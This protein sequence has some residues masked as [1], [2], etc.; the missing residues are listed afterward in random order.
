VTARIA[1]ALLAVVA[2][3]AAVAACG[4]TERVPDPSGSTLRTTW[5]DTDGDGALEP[6]PGEALLRRTELAPAGQPGREIARLG[7]VTDVHLADEESPAHLPFL[8]RLGPPFSSTFRPQEALQPRVLTGIVRSLNDARPQAVLEGGD[9]AD[10]AQSN[11]LRQAQSVLDGGLVRPDTGGR[12]YEGPQL[13]SNPDPLFYRP[14]VDAPRYEGLLD[15]AARPFRSPGLRAPWHPVLGNHDILVAGELAPT[16]KTNALATGDRALTR[17]DREFRLPR[18]EEALAPGAVDRVLAAGLPGVTERRTP[19]P[20]R[21]ELSA[22][23][24]VA[25]L[26]PRSAGARLDYSFDVGRELRVIALDIVARDR[27]SGGRVTEATLAFLRSELARAG[28][29]RIAVAT[30]QPLRSSDGGA[31]V[32]ALLDHDRRVVATLAGHTHRNRIRPR[33]TAAGGYWQIETASL[34]D[35]PQQARMLALVRTAGGGLALSTWLVD[36]APG[37]PWVDAA[38]RLAYLD[39]QGGRPTGAASRPRDRNALLF[40]PR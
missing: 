8:D 10:S 15:A 5:R 4:S 29:R 30:H 1:A 31:R 19:D 26:R 12:G 38:R 32:L 37:D 23:E 17:L 22:S 2:L 34:A 20:G 14:D 16:P 39:V 18:G 25:R 27:G 36:P 9:L 35:Y 6:R 33:Q 40:L 28:D 3:G 21:R 11:E 24:A 7:I 13:A